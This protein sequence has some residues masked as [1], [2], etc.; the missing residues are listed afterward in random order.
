MGCHCPAERNETNK[1]K[2]LS[3]S[4]QQKSTF[5]PFD[6]TPTKTYPRQE[7]LMF[8]NENTKTSNVTKDFKT[9]VESNYNFHSYLH[10]NNINSLCFALFNEINQLRTKPKTYIAKI[11]KYLPYITNRDDKK[12]FNVGSDV[13]ISLNTGQE[14]FENAIA[15]LSGVSPMSPLTLSQELTIEIEDS[16]E[17]I[18]SLEYIKKAYTR[19]SES[20]KD[21][22]DIVGFHYDKSVDNAEISALLQIVD[23]T[24]ANYVRRNNIMNPR[25]RYVGISAS[26]VKENVYCF[27]LVFGNKK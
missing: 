1:E 18:T 22:F 5:P 21:F 12:L 17:D 13:F 20:V 7:S 10:T 4:S 23:D 2:D 19:K 27:Y 8:S 9:Y 26:C 16:E 6:F 25:A 11:A 14:A 15:Y 24:G 3:S